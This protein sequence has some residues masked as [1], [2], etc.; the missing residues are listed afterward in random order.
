M[1]SETAYMLPPHNEPPAPPIYNQSAQNSRTTPDVSAEDAYYEL[2]LSST[3][4]SSSESIDDDDILAQATEFTH[5]VPPPA[6][7]PPVLAKPIAVPQTVA[8]MAQPFSRCW[9]PSLAIYNITAADFVEF[10]DNLNVVAT[11]SPPLQVLGLVGGV[12]SM[13][14]HHIFILTGIGVQALAKVGAVA[15]SKSRTAMYMKA[16]NEQFF[17]PRGLKASIMQHE[18][19]SVTLGLPP[20]TDVLAPVTAETINCSVIER[21]LEKMK[22]HIA[23]IEFDVPA[24]AVQ[25]TILAKMSA[26]QV[27]RQAARNEKKLLKSR[28]KNFKDTVDQNGEP[29]K[30]SSYDQWKH[31]R[32]T[33]RL[34]AKAERVQREAERDS[35]EGGRHARRAERK[36]ERKQGRIEAKQVRVDRELQKKIQPTDKESKQAKKGL[37]ILIENLH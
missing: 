2:Y 21:R 27:K 19:L 34:E 8:G 22:P 25:T 9:S 13:V 30:G 24:P 6:Y 31:E 16:V 12:I 5:H 10:I 17:A 33:R 11:A 28:T 3:P 36:L 1:Y 15:V 4:S 14:P 29:R 7:I 20:D 23:P 18:A 26:A 32:K 35:R 37:W